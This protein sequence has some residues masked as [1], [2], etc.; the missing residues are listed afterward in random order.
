MAS[1]RGSFP[2]F[3]ICR[4]MSPLLIVVPTFALASSSAR[5]VKAAAHK[6]VRRRV[7]G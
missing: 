6:N 2:S 5:R 1:S 3:S 4:M 7:D